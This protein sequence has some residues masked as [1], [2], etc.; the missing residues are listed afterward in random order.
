MRDRAGGRSKA[1][2]SH[3][4]SVSSE[5]IRLFSLSRSTQQRQCLP[6]GEAA[7]SLE[8]RRGSGVNGCHCVSDAV[9]IVVGRYSGNSLL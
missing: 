1:G 2:V 3:G 5:R 7:G 6:Y 8:G 9:L 4:V